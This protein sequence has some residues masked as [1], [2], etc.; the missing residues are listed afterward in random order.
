MGFPK[1]TDP[2]A[3]PAKYLSRS[4][5]VHMGYDPVAKK[6]GDM[7]CVACHQAKKDASGNMLDHGIGGFMYHSV[8]QGEMKECTDCHTASIHV[9]TSVEGIVRTH[10]RLACQACH[11][12]AFA[13]KVAT[14]VDWRWSKA[15]L[16]ARPADCAASPTGVAADGVTQR[17]TYNKMKG[18]FTWGTN[19]RP[20][21]RF[22]DG[23]WNRIIVGFNDKYTTQPVDLGS[24]S[25]SYK[26][27]AAKIYTFKKMTGNQ[28]ADKG[29]KTMFV[30]HLHGTAAGPNAYWSKYDWAGSLTDA[31]NYLPAYNAGSQTF[32]G[33]YE[34]VN[35]VMLLKVDHEV[36]PKE[37]AYGNGGDCGDCHLSGQIEWP[38]LGWTKDPA[39][40]GE[41][42]LP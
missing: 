9:G 34:F 6:G 25:A 12:P 1:A 17:G 5:D 33:A 31:M 37:M 36:A 15:G 4:E 2:A 22:Y 29:N 14:Y 23:K 20:A 7:T 10:D 26:D 16:D 40:G 41:Q 30:P 18:C 28:V 24:P 3:D 21:L 38:A 32:T 27:P 19:V 8:D 39:Q 42:T 35:T 13:R 11:I